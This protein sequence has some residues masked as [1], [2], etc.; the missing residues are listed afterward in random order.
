MQRFVFKVS[1]EQRL[2]QLLL[3]LLLFI[4]AVFVAAGVFIRTDSRLDRIIAQEHFCVPV[5]IIE[6]FRFRPKQP[7]KQ[8]HQLVRYKETR[9]R[10]IKI[11]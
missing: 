2:V 11:I 6:T 7:S 3:H 5:Q 10:K 4:L 8:R 9:Y 1:N